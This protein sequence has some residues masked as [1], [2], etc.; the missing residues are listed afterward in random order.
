MHGYFHNLESLDSYN[1][2]KYFVNCEVNTDHIN[3]NIV[4]NETHCV[5]A[6]FHS[7]VK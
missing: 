1:V 6:M 7:N 4:M 3:I 5:I 2:Q